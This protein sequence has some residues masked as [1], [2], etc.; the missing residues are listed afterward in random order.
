MARNVSPSICLLDVRELW[1]SMRSSWVNKSDYTINLELGG[2]MFWVI[3]AKSR[4]EA[5]AICF[6]WDS[7]KMKYPTGQGA[8]A[9]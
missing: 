9:I 7:G 6:S 4:E 5:M 2:I 8:K 3:K 1:A